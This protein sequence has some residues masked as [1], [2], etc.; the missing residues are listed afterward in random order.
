[1]CTEIALAIT[2]DVEPPDHPRTF[3][4]VLL[5]A[6]VHPTPRATHRLAEVLR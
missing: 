6:R 1:M 5:H 4:C 2:V 3:D